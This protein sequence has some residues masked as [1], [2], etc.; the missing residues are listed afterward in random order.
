[1]DE[2]TL[3][4]PLFGKEVEIVIYDTDEILAEEVADRAY[5]EGIR[6]S[7]IFNLYDEKSELS[8]LNK[9]RKMRVSN[10]LI[11]VLNIAGRFYRMTNGQYDVSLGKSI[12]QRKQG[13]KE[14][15]KCSFKDVTME[16]NVVTLNHE[17][18][19]ID[20][21]SIAKGFI[22]DKMV[23]ILENEGVSSGLVDGRGDIRIFGEVIQNI[24]IQHPRDKDKTIVNINVTD[25][26]IATSG[27]YNQYH[28]S[29][30]KS[31]IINSKNLAS[32]TVVAPTLTIAD[33]FA[34]AFFVSNSPELLE[35][36]KDVSAM[37]IDKHLNIKYYNG[38]EELL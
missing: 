26:G 29:F 3:R 14:T 21:G 17:D 27:D 37:T 22:V 23:E 18:V 15:A 9:S 4:K 36:Y 13:L 31:H 10:E 30:E 35:R 6:L 28:G 25:C 20:L 33:V 32:I 7:K 1:M 12:H 24:G 38:F 2:F 19:I 8:S 11:E 5:K 16:G 34:T